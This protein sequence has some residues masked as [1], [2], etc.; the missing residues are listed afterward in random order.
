MRIRPFAVV[1]LAA[2]L[3]LPGLVPADVK[4]PA[5]ISDHM[6]VQQGMPVPIWGWADAGEKVT[7]TACGDKTEA[8][9]GADGKFCAKIGPFK[10]GE[11]ME[12]TVAG[13]NTIVIKDVLVGEV[14]VASGQSNMQ[15]TVSNSANP[16]EE[17]AAAKFPKMRLFSVP[18][19]TA[20]K[21]Q[22]DVKASWCECSPE[23]VP[24]FSAV[25]YF[26]GRE[27]HQKLNVP[28]GMIHTSWGGTPAEAWT[29][30]ETMQA[31]FKPIADRWAKSQQDWE[32]GA[33]TKAYEAQMA[34]WKDAAEKIKAANKADAD[35]AAKAGKPKPKARPLPRQPGKPGPATNSPHCP[36]VLYNAM[37]HPL[38][39][40]AIRGAIW[41]QGES[42]AGRAYQYRDL[43]PAMITDW[44]KV[45]GQGD[46]QFLFVQLANFM[47][48]KNEPADSAW[49][50][51]REAQTMT[52]ALPNTGMAVI[53]DIGEAG[54][55]HPKNKQDVGKRLAA[56]ALGTTYGQKVCISG[57]LY[58]SMSV[59]GGK[60]RLKF[61]HVGGGLVAKG[62]KLTGFSIAGEDK[63][64]V[65]ADAVIDGECVVVCSDKVAAP[66]AVRYAWADNPECNLYN[67]AGLP[68]SPF[69]TDDW[70]GVT[71][72]KE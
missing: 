15:W 41:Y 16:T 70:P 37:I 35:K 23:T 29:T 21:P 18:R 58:D 30:Q 46:F 6:V 50:E 9:A 34:K 2:M 48:R 31:K 4:L 64:F 60:V 1:L 59:D 7:I 56:W 20:A 45:W 68:A 39:P 27:L 28:V 11:P 3:A 47:A 51:L 43:F 14:W 12:I 62:D 22:D 17:I 63:K 36:A 10:T 24:G 72:G 71:A 52:L 5:V 67:K 44:R 42:N 61:K 19:V 32:S 38:V 13:K 26:F 25:A 40:Y 33:A 57:P 69:R 66:K 8:T 54:N 55:I 53:I 49:A 65:W